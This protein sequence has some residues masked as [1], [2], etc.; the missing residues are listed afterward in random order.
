M[1]EQMLDELV[2]TKTILVN[3]SP[4]R[5][6]RVYTEEI[7]TWWPF[8][9]THSVGEEKTETVIFEPGVGGRLFERE[10]DGTEHLWG[11]VLEWDP[12]RRVVHSWHPGRDEA[13]AQR[14]E[15][16]FSAEGEQTRVELEHRGW[17]TLG[18]EAAEM[19]KKYDE[20]WE[21]VLGERFAR[22][23]G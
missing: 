19:Y 8:S 4:E 12:P 21:Y 23:L 22:V 7:A 14:V 20:G 11:T 3:A 1:S 6:F 18:A 5:A 15:L 2:L 17:E 10:R 9:K 13:S 16:R